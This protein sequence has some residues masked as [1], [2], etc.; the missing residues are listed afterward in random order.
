MA[1][2]A[3]SCKTDNEKSNDHIIAEYSAWGTSFSIRNTDDAYCV[4]PKD[5]ITAN[6][7]K[8]LLIDHS[9]NLGYWGNVDSEKFEMWDSPAV[10]GGETYYFNNMFAHV[11]AEPC[12]PNDDLYETDISC[13]YEDNKVIIGEEEYTIISISERRVFALLKSIYA[14]DLWN[15]EIFV[16]KD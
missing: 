15:V 5:V 6:S 10:G 14:P 3:I 13:T 9:W 16:R 2:L 12:D 4:I 1:I 7:I 11:M 8:A